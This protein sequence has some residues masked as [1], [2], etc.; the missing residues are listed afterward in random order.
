M[1]RFDVEKLPSEEDLDHLEVRQNMKGM[2]AKR[3][4]ETQTVHTN[5]NRR[6]KIKVSLAPVKWGDR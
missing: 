2:W 3:D 6:S 1:H 5:Q 4:A